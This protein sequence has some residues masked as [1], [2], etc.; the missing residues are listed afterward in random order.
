MSSFENYF[1]CHEIYKPY[2]CHC[3]DKAHPFFRHINWD[4]LLARKVEPPFKPFLVSL[5]FLRSN[6]LCDLSLL[7][8]LLTGL[9][10]QQSADDAS[11]FDSKFTSQTPVDSPDDSTLSESANQVFLVGNSCQSSWQAVVITAVL[12]Q[13]LV[14]RTGL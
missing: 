10:L 4:D 13:F 1:S 3:V 2:F 14:Y 9:F 12:S 6:F 11:Q 5:P 8:D 7:S